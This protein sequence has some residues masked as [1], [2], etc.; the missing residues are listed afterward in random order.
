MTD[1]TRRR[2]CPHCDTVTL[3]RHVKAI[4]SLIGMA[5]RWKCGE[6]GAEIVLVRL[7]GEEDDD[8]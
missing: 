2:W 8:A 4:V 3:H 1:L 6:C 5:D 7:G